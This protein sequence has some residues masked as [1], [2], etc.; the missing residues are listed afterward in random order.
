VR[1]GAVLSHPRRAPEPRGPWPAASLADGV[2]RV[3]GRL[4]GGL[5]LAPVNL[6]LMAEGERESALESL[7]A[8]YDA[9]PRPF[10]LLS[11]PTD[12]PPHEHLGA[13]EERLSGRRAREWFRPYASLYRDLAWAPRRPLRSTYLLVDAPSAPELER[14]L[15]VVGRMAE[16]QGLPARQVN[17]EDLAGLWSDVARVGAGYRVAAGIATGENVLAAAALGRRW[18]AEVAPGWLGALLAVPGLAAAAMR[19]RP[20]SRPEAMAFLTTR[21]RQ[22]R[23]AERLADERGEL[24]DVARERLG[25]TAVAGRRRVHAGEGR[26]YLVD[27]VFLV[28]APD[29]AS[30]R[31]RLELLRLEA[32]AADIDLDPAT[33]RLAD[34]WAACLPG[35]APKPIAERNLDSAS[36]AASLLHAAS[37]LYEPSGHLYGI[38]RRTEAPIVIDRF[39]HASHNAIVLGQTGTGKTMFTGA[40]M[41]RSFLRGI[42]VLAVDPLG[43][44]R[45]LT[46]ELGGTYLELGS[47]MGLNPFALTGAVGDVGLTAKLAA[48]TRLVAAMVGGLSRDERPV[49]D[50]ALRAVYDAAGI[51]PD[52]ATH[53][54]TP[55]TIAD[56]AIRLDDLPGGKP[57]AHRLERWASG[58]LASLFAAG[59]APPLDRRMLVVGLAAISDPEVRAVAQLAALGVL[60]DAVRRDLAPKLV[61][62]DEAWKVMRQPS[63]AEFVEELA[64]SARHYHAGLQL[65]TQDIVEFLRS[66]VGEPI[67]KQCDIRVL[68]GQT[69]EGADS[70]ARY[71]DLT[72]AERRLLLHARPGEG[73]LF[74]GR[75]HVAFEAI[76]ADRE[77]AALTTRPADLADPSSP[78]R[79]A[80]PDSG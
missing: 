20:L 38:A 68:F 30:L 65:A 1:L 41:G 2:L 21:L 50:R 15:G 40:E 64:R 53:D 78:M 39:A 44:Y 14:A 8:L 10:T 6:E 76:V 29:R 66:D 58:S 26:L 17:S 52:P 61:V 51:G 12:R 63:G 46:A 27:T 25:A 71:F 4:V 43:D 77:Y 33:F 74:V 34:A 67:V 7:A 45:R 73:L 57:L 80:P 19:V 72:A 28:E 37:D 54:R 55:P 56:L 42:R 47:G 35:P 24:S 69:P 59:G 22:V 5:E 48:L 18:P 13:I 9:V 11:V 36:L 16:E 3:E 60:W 49:L 75:S 32:K 31:E 70:L 62:V 23:A 79:S